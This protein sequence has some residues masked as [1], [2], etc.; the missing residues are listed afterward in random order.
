MSINKYEVTQEDRD[1]MAR[2]MT[3]DR[4]LKHIRNLSFYKFSIGD[5]LIRQERRYVDAD[6]YEWKTSMHGNLPY[7][8]VYVFENDLGVGYIRRLSVNGRKFVE[9]PMCV[10]EFD[11]DTTQFVVDP[12]YADHLMLASEEDDFDTKSRYD[13]AKRRREQ[14]NRKNK[15]L[16]IPMADEAA[17]LTWMQ[18][19]K[20]GDQFWFGHSIG[21]INKEPYYVNEVCL[22]EP[23]EWKKQ[24]SSYWTTPTFS[25]YIKASTALT[26]SPSAYLNT[27]YANNISRYYIFQQRP[28]FLDEQVT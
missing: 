25:P 28:H 2:D 13:E 9:R 15:K 21:G 6:H 23:P 17:A 11:P 16:A 1:I 10:T 26:P 19:L 7:K 14:T 22:V 20:V 18:S 3:T 24:N 12:E 5:V 4:T 8:Y 27:F